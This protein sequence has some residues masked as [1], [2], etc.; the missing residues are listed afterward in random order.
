MGFLFLIFIVD[1]HQQA[2]PNKMNLKTPQSE[3]V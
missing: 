2:N 3:A 1:L